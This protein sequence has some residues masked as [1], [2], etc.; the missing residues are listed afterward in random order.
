MLEIEPL[1]VGR[2]VV[3]VE[4]LPPRDLLIVLDADPV[5]D[6]GNV[7]RLRLSV[8]PDFPRLHLQLGRR[9]KHQG[10]AA[11]FYAAVGA[12]LEGCKLTELRQ[13][14]GDRIVRLVF[15]RPGEPPRAILA[16]FA[17]RHGNLVLTEGPDR[18]AGLLVPPPASKTDPRLVIGQVW[19]APSG[20]PPPRAANEPGLAALLPEPDEH[21]AGA[22]RA[23][24]SWRVEWHLGH[25]DAQRFAD[26]K[27][28]RLAD[29]LQRKLGRARALVAGLEAKRRSADGCE[30]V[31]QDGELLKANVHA[32]GRGL[33]RAVLV[34]W[35]AE[36]AGE[37]EEQPQRT[38]A[39]DPSLDP[40]AN[41]ERYFARYKKLL[42]A[43]AT[44]EEELE[45][46]RV[47]ERE[48]EALAARVDDPALDA[49]A[50]DALALEAVEGG[51]LE[52]EQQADPRKQKPAAERRPYRSFSGSAG[53]EIR[54]GRSA[55]DNDT[56]T[57]RHAHGNDLWLHTADAPGSHVVLKLARNAEPDSD[58]VL[59]AAHL[60]IHFSPLREAH[61]ADV[62]VARR[63]EVHKPR[64]AKPGLVTLSAGRRMTVRVQP[65]RL[66][67]LLRGS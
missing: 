41:A 44:V 9:K 31:L 61:K 47:R 49:E 23:P 56:L 59:D 51:L 8:S 52:P 54:V 15:R 50:V 3:D 29:R 48:L 32:L 35:F 19:T 12:A 21:P 26:K 14:Q 11:P 43:A 25:A 37:G 42:R 10:S 66:E 24:L 38:I 65:A 30:R 67:R 39:L 16:E 33:E 62:H 36:P 40:L 53:S 34:D 45:R 18:V 6:G 63:K 7:R 5:A 2:G 1:V 60:A 20:K 58:E 28:K 46:A 4:A 13:L 22:E 64:G 17:G 55:R 27:K 57:F